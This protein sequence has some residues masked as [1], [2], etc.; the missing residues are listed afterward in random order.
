VSSYANGPSPDTYN[1]VNNV[2]NASTQSG[3][4]WQC[5]ELVNRLYLTKGWTTS[6]WSGNGNQLYGNAPTGLTKEPNGSVTYA[7][8]GDVIGMSKGT[9]PGHVA[10]VSSVSGNSWTIASQN[11]NIVYDTGFGLSSGTIT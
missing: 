9:G 8:S 4:E 1:Y 6:T 3:I 11:T 2:N 7:N 10:I 5:V